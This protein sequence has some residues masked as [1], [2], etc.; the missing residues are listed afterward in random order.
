MAQELRIG[1]HLQ[2][3]AGRL[4]RQPVALLVHLQLQIAQ[5]GPGQLDQI[6]ELRQARPVPRCG[7]GPA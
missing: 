3:L 1:E 4:Q 2:H 7:E 5:D 6:D